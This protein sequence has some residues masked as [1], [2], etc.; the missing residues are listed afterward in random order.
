VLRPYRFISWWWRKQLF[1]CFCISWNS[2]SE[3]WLRSSFS[4]CST[5]VMQVCCNLTAVCRIAS[6]SCL[7]CSSWLQ[8]THTNIAYRPGKPEHKFMGRRDARAWQNNTNYCYLKTGLYLF[9]ECSLD[10]T[11]VEL[12][13]HIWC[14]TFCIHNQINRSRTIVTLSIVNFSMNRRGE[15]GIVPDLAV[16]SD[17]FCTPF[18]N[19]CSYSVS[20]E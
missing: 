12:H 4:S 20:V 11:A 6:K 10:V 13:A 1:S 9:V 19:V 2:S 18:L 7:S 16:A 14:G 15:K 8:A 5:A 3:H 17:R